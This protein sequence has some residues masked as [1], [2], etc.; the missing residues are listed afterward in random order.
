MRPGQGISRN[1]ARNSRTTLIRSQYQRSCPSTSWPRCST[2]GLN[3]RELRVELEHAAIGLQRARLVVG[4]HEDMAEAG[5]GVEMARLELEGPVAGR[6]WR[7]PDRRSGRRRS[8]A[9]YHASAQF[10]WRVT[11]RSRSSMAS[12]IILLPTASVARLRR[13][14]AV[15]EPERAKRRS[16]RQVI[17]CASALVFGLGQ[18]CRR[19]SSR[20][21]ARGASAG[22]RLRFG[23]PRTRPRASCAPKGARPGQR[24]DRSRTST[25]SACRD[26]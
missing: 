2:M 7:R 17:P 23:A 24:C 20:V 18:A 16:M 6:P 8:P 3:G 26:L 19:D 5:P 4:G 9:V 21:T 13:R 25:K 22:A 15:S 10:G 14:S 11:T 12:A 1:A